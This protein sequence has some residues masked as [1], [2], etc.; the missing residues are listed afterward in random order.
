MA[1]KAV[2]ADRRST[3]IPCEI[4]AVITS[5][6]PCHSFSRPCVIVLVNLQGCTVRTQHPFQ[7]GTAVRLEGL[8][9]GKTPNAR[10]VN[11]ISFGEQERLW[12]LGIALVAPGN[13][14]DIKSPPAD[15]TEQGPG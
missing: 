1:S 15:W 7:V 9:S 2:T 10:I 8:P 11:S 3:R 4:P 6:D 14:W 13:V 5:L 12:L